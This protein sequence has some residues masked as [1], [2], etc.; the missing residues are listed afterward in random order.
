[1]R[2]ELTAILLPLALGLMCSLPARAQDDDYFRLPDEVTDEYLDTVNVKK[3]FMLNDYSM[4]G[5]Y[6]GV[7]LTNTSFNPRKYS[8]MGFRQG[9]FGIMWTRYGK[10]FGY[11]PHF[12]MQIGIFHNWEG[13]HFQE[14]VE[15]GTTPVLDY[16]SYDTGADIET[17]EVPILSHFHAEI[18][19]NFKILANAGIYG[20]YRLSIE[21]YGANVPDEYRHSFKEKDTRLDYGFL[22]GAGFG[23]VFDPFEIHLTGMFKWGWS[24]LYAPD[25]M[26]QY[27]YRFAYPM[28]V[29]ITL[30]IHY[31]LSPRFGM[32]RKQLRQRAREIVES[33]KLPQEWT[34]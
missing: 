18:G 9:T 21:R 24:S 5:A 13:Y 33:K 30:S 25:Y 28:D 20:G 6:Y 19:N 29:S 10:M 4:I 1:M 31:Q 17:V 26:N 15:S 8:T 23:L 7:A 14:D 16:V 2:K 27:A 12:G 32:T 3:K 22:G 11:M 34:E